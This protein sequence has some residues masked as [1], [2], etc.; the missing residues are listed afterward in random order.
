[1][2]ENLKKKHGHCQQQNYVSKLGELVL[3]QSRSIFE[4]MYPDPKVSRVQILIFGFCILKDTYIRGRKKK[5][6]G[7]NLENIFCAY[8]GN[9]N[10]NFKVF[11]NFNFCNPLASP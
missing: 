2:E 8:I 4:L 5:Y 6:L 10:R 1:M 7:S 9:Y 11:K 3:A